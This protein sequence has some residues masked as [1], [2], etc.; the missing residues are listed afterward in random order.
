[1]TKTV[2]QNK[3]DKDIL[4]TVLKSWK[5]RRLVRNGSENP[6]KECWNWL[7]IKFSPETPETES[8]IRKLLIDTCSG[9]RKTNSLSRKE[10]TSIF[11]AVYRVADEVEFN[12][13]Y[14]GMMKLMDISDDSTGFFRDIFAMVEKSRIID[15][16]GDHSVNSL[17]MEWKSQDALGI[18]EYFAWCREK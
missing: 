9:K 12:E 1:M 5:I 7:S 2:C 18:K 11:K 3:D 16:G 10:V 6:E 14:D 15:G 4:K 8:L 17:I 13:N